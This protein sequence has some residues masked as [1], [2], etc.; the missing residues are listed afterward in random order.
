MN[1]MQT[2]I[3]SVELILINVFLEY[4]LFSYCIF[5]YIKLKQIAECSGIDFIK[6]Y[7]SF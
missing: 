6:I 4:L 1:E 5:M 7:V 3:F 2:S